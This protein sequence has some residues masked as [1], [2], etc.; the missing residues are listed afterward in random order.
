MEKPTGGA[1]RTERRPHGTVEEEVADKMGKGP[2]GLF[3]HELKEEEG[4]DPTQ[5]PQ[6]CARANVRYAE[7]HMAPIS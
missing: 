7:R 2:E 4:H 1:T 3:Q 6:N 5:K